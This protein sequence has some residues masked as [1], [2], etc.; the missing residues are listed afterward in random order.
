MLDTTLRVGI[1][2]LA[3]LMAVD[4][5]ASLIGLEA[6]VVRAQVHRGYWPTV[7]VGKRLLVNV[8][9]VRLKAAERGAEYA[10]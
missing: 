1:S 9:A 7:K 6:S 3:P 2:V 5:F 8:E 10:L 4:A